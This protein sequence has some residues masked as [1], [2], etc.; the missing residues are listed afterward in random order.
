MPSRGKSKDDKMAGSYK[1]R[2]RTVG[3]DL[4]ALKDF[5]TRNSRQGGAGLFFMV[6]EDRTYG[7]G[8]KL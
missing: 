7:N 1:E 6:T 8:V 4:I 5:L 3:G 2:L